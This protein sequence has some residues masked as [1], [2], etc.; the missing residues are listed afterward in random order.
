MDPTL[1]LALYLAVVA[2]PLSLVGWTAIV[3]SMSV[4]GRT[5]GDP[6]W[7]W[8]VAKWFILNKGDGQRTLD[9]KGGA[10]L[11][12][13]VDLAPVLLLLHDPYG[14]LC[15]TIDLAYFLVIA[16]LVLH[17]AYAIHQSRS[18]KGLR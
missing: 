1:Q 18:S 13:V 10:L 11:I 12:A 8:F 2:M 7:L 15:L 16:L 3:T 4:V 17:T 5:P 6:R 14:S 9:A